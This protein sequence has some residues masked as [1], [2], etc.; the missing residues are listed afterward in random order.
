MPLQGKLVVCCKSPFITWFS[1]PTRV[2]YRESSQERVSG[3][4]EDKRFTPDW[5]LGNFTLTPSNTS[6]A[7]ADFFVTNV[8]LKFFETCLQISSLIYRV[9]VSAR[10]SIHTGIKNRLQYSKL[11]LSGTVEDTRDAWQCI[12]LSTDKNAKTLAS[13]CCFGR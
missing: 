11:L 10:S 12:H 2:E 6:V 7:R 5:F 1:I 4:R 3:D 13:P 8:K 9:T